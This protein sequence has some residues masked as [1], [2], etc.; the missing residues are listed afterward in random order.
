MVHLTGSQKTRDVQDLTSQYYDG[1]LSSVGSLPGSIDFVHQ[2]IWRGFLLQSLGF[3][4]S[5][6]AREETISFPGPFVIRY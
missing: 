3:A 2:E 1:P 5:E 4:V 6:G